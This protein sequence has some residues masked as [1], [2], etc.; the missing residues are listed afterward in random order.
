MVKKSK[1]LYPYL[2]SYTK[3]VYI[4]TKLCFYPDQKVAC[5]NRVEV[6]IYNVNIYVLCRMLY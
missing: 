6:A 1:K 5:L 3:M 2:F 4:P